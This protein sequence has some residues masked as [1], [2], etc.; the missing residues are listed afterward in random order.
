MNFGRIKFYIFYKK[1]NSPIII[2][3][4]QSLQIDTLINY[5]TYLKLKVKLKK[6]FLNQEKINKSINFAKS[7]YNTKVFY[8]NN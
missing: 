7:M 5:E 6:K 2:L 8:G 3:T 1:F 4:T